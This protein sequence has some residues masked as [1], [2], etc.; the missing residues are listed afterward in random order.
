MATSDLE[1]LRDVLKDTLE[2]RGVLGQVKARIRAEIFAALDDNNLPPPKLSNEN[3]IINELIREYLE[4][5]NYRQSLSVFLPETGQPAE[6]AQELKRSFLA[7]QLQVNENSNSERVPLLYGLLSKYNKKSNVESA[8]N[9]IDKQLN[10]SASITEIKHV[11]KTPGNA[12]IGK[13]RALPI[14]EN[15]LSTNEN[16]L[17]SG[18][19]PMGKLCVYN[20]S[21]FANTLTRFKILHPSI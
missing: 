16:I 20:L 17:A 19:Q 14:N 12:S 1:D 5:N 21:F 2:N 8:R 15:V 4:Y 10:N 6:A 9:V 13:N 11:N 18:S 3:L 7:K